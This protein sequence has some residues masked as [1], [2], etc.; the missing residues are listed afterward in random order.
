MSGL[1][2]DSLAT[3]PPDLVS[4]TQGRENMAA[5]ETG[6]LIAIIC[7]R[8]ERL[9]ERHLRALMRCADELRSLGAEI[10]LLDGRPD[11]ASGDETL[12]AILPR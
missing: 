1:D 11:P 2:S 4:A 3:P 12:Q 10:L 6:L 5:G 7:D 8:D 9:I